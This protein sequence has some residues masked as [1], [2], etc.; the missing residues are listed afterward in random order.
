MIEWY[1]KVID[2]SLFQTQRAPRRM[3][4]TTTSICASVEKTCTCREVRRET[5]A[6]SSRGYRIHG[7]TAKGEHGWRIETTFRRKKKNC[8]P[9]E[10]VVDVLETSKAAKRLGG[11]GR[12]C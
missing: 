10:I 3:P 1:Q 6:K 5:A 9:G 4:V 7:L 8:K 2:A 12:R 11:G